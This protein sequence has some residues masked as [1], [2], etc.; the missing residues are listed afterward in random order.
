MDMRKA[1]EGFDFDSASEEDILNRTAAL[2]KRENPNATDAEL[3]EFA[4]RYAP[5]KTA[6]PT[7]PAPQEASLTGEGGQGIDSAPIAQDEQSESATPDAPAA[8]QNPIAPTIAPDAP[9][10]D[11]SAFDTIVADVKKTASELEAAQT[12]QSPPTQ[13]TIA[14]TPQSPQAQTTVPDWPQE[15]GANVGLDGRPIPEPP[16]WSEPTE[17]SWGEAIGEG[18]LRAFKDPTN[19]IGY[20]YQ[21]SRL[22]GKAVEGVGEFADSINAQAEQI[23]QQIHS[24]AEI[25]AQNENAAIYSDP[26]Q[27]LGARAR[28]YG[29][30]ALSFISAPFVE[31]PLDAAGNIINKLRGEKTS[32]EKTWEEK[33]EERSTWFNDNDQVVL[34]ALMRPA[35]GYDGVF[36]HFTGGKPDPE[37]VKKYNEQVFERFHHKFDFKIMQ[38]TGELLARPKGSDLPFKSIHGDLF[39]GN[40]FTNG[41]AAFFPELSA[42][43]TGDILTYWALKKAGAIGKFGQKIAGSKK[44]QEAVAILGAIGAA[45]VYGAGGRALQIASTGQEM[46]DEEY[47]KQITGGS[48]DN[49][50]ATMIG[51][52]APSLFRGAWQGAKNVGGKIAYYMPQSIESGATKFA[53]RYIYKTA[54]KIALANQERAEIEALAKD[55]GATDNRL[56]HF[57]N[58]EEGRRT[59]A[60]FP[61]NATALRQTAIDDADALMKTLLAKLNIS[62]EQSRDAFKFIIGGMRR[63]KRYYEALYDGA[64]SLLIKKAGGITV[65]GSSET[66]EAIAKATREI[67]YPANMVGVRSEAINT[68]FNRDASSALST[69]A[70]FFR[71]DGKIKNEFTLEG[72]FRLQRTLNDLYGKHADKFSFS[73]KEHINTIRKAIYKD[74]ETALKASRLPNEVKTEAIDLWRGVNKEYSQYKRITQ[75][76]RIIKELLQ[77]KEFD[78]GRWVEDMLSFGGAID[79]DNIAALAKMAQLIRQKRPTEMKRFYDAIANGMIN[80]ARTPANEVAH[81]KFYTDW[82]TF[83]KLWKSID[84]GAKKQIFADDL[85]KHYLKTLNSLETIAEREA[86]LQGVLFKGTLSEAGRQHS[87]ASRIWLFSRR[88]ALGVIFLDRIAPYWIRSLA[89]TRYL[90][91]LA[92]KT[93]FE[94]MANDGLI[95]KLANDAAKNRG[96][97][98]TFADV[99]ALKAA[100]AQLEKIGQN[101]PPNPTRQEVIDAIDENL[102]E[103]QRLLGFEPRPLIEYRPNFIL[104]D[105]ALPPNAPRNSPDAPNGNGGGGNGNGGGNGGGG[106]GGNGSGGGGG[107]GS[108]GGG[109]PNNPNNPTDDGWDLPPFD[110]NLP[111]NIIDDTANVAAR[112]TGERGSGGGSWDDLP[113]A[114]E[115]DPNVNLVRDSAAQAAT[116]KPSTIRAGGTDTS[117][118]ATAGEPMTEMQRREANEAAKQAEEK[119]Q[120]AIALETNTAPLDSTPAIKT[121]ELVDYDNG[122]NAVVE[123]KLVPTRLINT[124]LKL[125]G[126]VQFRTKKNDDV[127]NAIHKNFNAAAHFAPQGSYAGTPIV[128]RFGEPL[129]GNHRAEAIKR[130]RGEQYERYLEGLKK[131]YPEAA[132]SIKDGET[133]MLVRVINEADE[134]TAARLAKLSNK[135]AVKGEAEKITVDEATFKDKLDK[136]FEK[137]QKIESQTAL[138]NL[139]DAK[140][141]LDS[142]R[143]MIGRLNEELPNA[144]DE[145]INIFKDDTS[146]KDMIYNNAYGLFNLRQAAI[147]APKAAAVDLT[148]ILPMAVRRMA[149]SGRN[150]K[151]NANDLAADYID[152]LKNYGGRDVEGNLITPDDLAAD[153]V[154]LALRR[155]RGLSS[156]GSG[157]F[158]KKIEALEALAQA[159]KQGNLLGE[160]AHPDRLDAAL[161]LFGEN[162]HEINNAVALMR[163]RQARTTPPTR[164]LDNGAP[165]PK[166][167]AAKT[168]E[169]A[170]KTADRKS[171]FINSQK[172]EPTPTATETPEPKNYIQEAMAADRK[173]REQDRA[174][175]TAAYWE[176]R[177]SQTPTDAAQEQAKAQKEAALKQE[178]HA[179]KS[180]FGYYNKIRSN[181]VFVGDFR[182]N[183]LLEELRAA[184]YARDIGRLE[185]FVKKR[186]QH[187]DPEDFRDLAQSMID[188]INATEKVK[189]RMPALPEAYRQEVEAAISQLDH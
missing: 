174:N 108:G 53:N 184:A 186:L 29:K 97:G 165:T 65:K 164:P 47:W 151:Q 31:V 72:L 84:A 13:T 87:L 125:D 91:S 48:V 117:R 161:V 21:A 99:K 188:A 41:M 23:R 187:N 20:A 22:A 36:A 123:Y 129:A 179:L 37:A 104:V 139:L 107:N 5:R 86:L 170:A 27:P 167:E 93:R 98:I 64:S 155:F 128:N 15:N 111:A 10:D 121:G 144:I 38:S 130:M 133:F 32:F 67:E 25:E 14:Q 49:V 135:G 154:G 59:L 148:P 80:A 124:V 40:A 189:T 85:G 103:A 68:E 127:I 106:G 177:K 42:T 34:Y 26:N 175:A 18:V 114:P 79:K 159:T 100:I 173:K 176:K 113:P 63:V 162:N 33:Q 45:P 109:K 115:F 83:L 82:E 172:T 44:A 150:N 145:Y 163:E 92:Q 142:N 39:D 185:T 24:P 76:T 30:N 75:D 152:R 50:I 102:I 143:A 43:V 168:Q 4:L 74:I 147:N 96:D 60:F 136:L 11:R 2:Y 89:F 132:Q 70:A 156:E 182:A 101:Q 3:K 78:A 105:D 54:D 171:D 35:G 110:P 120:R 126:K 95:N 140:N 169:Q 8:P 7:A 52:G 153:I 118:S 66:L 51:Y 122:I 57:A 88:Y 62:P 69:L 12:P 134:E 183:S 58:T 6:A 160:A 9:A 81:A 1:F 94:P 46:S 157:D 158:R 131:Y 137:P 112:Q 116:T 146:F 28:A 77:N 181:K 71:Q 19:P 73:Q 61:T 138:K 55:F 149:L 17:M 16:E 166:T 141:E 119:A 90:N 56:G 180:I 178:E